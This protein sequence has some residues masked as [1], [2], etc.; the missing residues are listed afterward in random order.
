MGEPVLARFGKFPTASVVSEPSAGRRSE[1][2]V[3]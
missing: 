3:A 1:G 2:G